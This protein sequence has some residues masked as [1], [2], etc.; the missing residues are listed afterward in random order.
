[1]KF[2]EQV[3]YDLNLEK[4]KSVSKSERKQETKVDINELNKRLNIAKR[5]NFYTTTLF[6]IFFLASIIALSIISI[7]F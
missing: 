4:F 6:V 5:A 1:M 3:I 7:K 2:K